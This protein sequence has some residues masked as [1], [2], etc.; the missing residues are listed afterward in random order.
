MNRKIQVITTF[1]LSLIIS[2]L[3]VGYI[4]NIMFVEIDWVNGVTLWDKFRVYYFDNLFSDSIPSLIIAVALT[5]IIR[6]ISR[7][8]NN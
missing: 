2:F 3:V 6:F 8:R 4:R 1:I 5:G 7:S